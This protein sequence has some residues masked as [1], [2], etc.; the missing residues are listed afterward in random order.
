M[1]KTSIKIREG[2]SNHYALSGVSSLFLAV[3]SFYFSN[4]LACIFVILS[5]VL[6]FVVTGIEV[7]EEELKY[8]KYK[9][10]LGFIAFGKWMRFS[11]EDTFHL[12]LSSESARFFSADRDVAWGFFM[13]VNFYNG[14]KSKLTT[15]DVVCVSNNGDKI[16]V[17]DFLKYNHAKD[18]LLLFEQSGCEVRNRIAEK[19][20]ENKNRKRS[21]PVL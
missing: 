11:K 15:F 9:I 6:F 10:F 12:I 21:K 18:T 2:L 14:N 19:I 13:P 3:I 8:R 1:S 7:D 16:Y 20:T 4:I 17:N 5:L